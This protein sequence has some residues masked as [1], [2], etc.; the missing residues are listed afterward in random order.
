MQAL[1]KA[2]SVRHS[3]MRLR[4]VADIVRGRSVEE[5]LAILGIMKNTRKGAEI[6][7]NVLKSA[8]A[9]L[10]Q[11]EDGAS[12]GSSPAGWPYHRHRA[13]RP[14]IHRRPDGMPV[15]LHRPPGRHSGPPAGSG[16]HPRRARSCR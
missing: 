9:N 16:D 13:S 14:G 5:S 15:R 6:V 12:A 4:Q 8:V 11:T 2:N 1:A 7:E 3:A 10:Q